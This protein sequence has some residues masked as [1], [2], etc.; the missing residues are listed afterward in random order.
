MKTT[1]RALFLLRLTSAPDIIIPYYVFQKTMEDSKILFDHSNWEQLCKDRL[2]SKDFCDVTIACR[3]ETQVE[4]HRIILGSQSGFF[5]KI[6]MANPRK[7]LLVYLPNL[8][9]Q[10]LCHLLEY[11]YFGKTEI[12]PHKKLA[13]VSPH[14]PPGAAQRSIRTRDFWRNWNFR[15]S[16]ISLKADRAL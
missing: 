16:W 12:K 14:H 5:N 2:A 10:D 13:L 7:D 6:L 9:H 3:D 11:I 8:D 15:L 1:H 4:A